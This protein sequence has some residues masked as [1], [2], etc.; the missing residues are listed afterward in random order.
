MG[1]FSV[2]SSHLLASLG[3]SWVHLSM[4][5]YIKRAASAAAADVSGLAEEYLQRYAVSSAV[6]R[7]DLEATARAEIALRGL[8]TDQ[9]LD[10]FTYQFL[11]FGE[12]ERV[13]TVPFV[14][15]SRLMAEGIGFGGEGDLVSAA[16]TALF[17]WLNPPATFSEVFTIDFAGNRLFMSHMGEANAGMARRDRRVPFVVRPTPITRTRDRQCALAL[18]LE[19]GPAT[20]G[21][22]TQGPDGR[23]RIIASPVTVTETPELAGFYV[24]YFLVQPRNDVREFL[25]AYAKAG[26]PHH[27]AI[28]FGDARPRLRLAAG[29]LHAD[30]L[31]I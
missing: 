17:H 23:W 4:E 7:Q 8:V 27:N 28:C 22:L 19:P 11:A 26:G 10:A 30:Y 9:R 25:T 1:D 2:D 16:G 15:A 24:P 12:D 5:D 21:A 18:S 6:T 13:S 31:E 3:C 29:L 14:A 20:L